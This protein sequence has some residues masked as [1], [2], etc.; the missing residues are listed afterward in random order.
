[1]KGKIGNEARLH[2]IL[3][4]IQEIEKYIQNILLEDFLKN[5][6]MQNA[7]I[8]WLEVIGEASR[9]ISEELKQQFPE[10]E[11]CEIV[12]LR[13]LL[14]HEYFGVDLNIV[15]SIIQFDLPLLKSKIQNVLLKL[16]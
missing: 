14:L 4:S 6:M 3:D 10:I 1:M 9:S 5:D 12:D 2:H 11:W 7:C 16:R 8:R 15:W 13:N